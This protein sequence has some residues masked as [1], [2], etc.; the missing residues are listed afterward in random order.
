MGNIKAALFLAYK[1]VTRGNR[2]AL[3]LIILVM[4]LSFMN[5]IFTSSILDGVTDTLDNQL[6]NTLVG[7]VVID[8]SGTDYYIEDTGNIKSKLE[9]V[10]GVSGVST[11][12]DSPAFIEYRWREKDRPDDKG[13]S[14]TWNVV[15][16]EPVAEA[17]VTTVH[18]TLIAGSYLEP[19]DR[20]RILL[21]I[22]I[23]GGEL[24]NSSD[25]LTLGGVAV[26]DWVRLSFPNGIVREYQI[27]GIFRAREIIVT[28]RQAFITRDEMT[29]VM[30]RS[31]F[32]DR[33]SQIIV[34]TADTGNEAT[35]V[36]SFIAMG[37]DGE[38]RAWYEYGAAMR[39]MVS[40]FQVVI[41][42]VSAIGLFVAGIVMFIVIYINVIHKR[43]QIGILRAIGIRRNVVV[44]SFLI[45]A[46]FYTITGVVFGW[47]IFSLAVE[48]Y[49]LMHPI[50]VSIGYISLSV[51]HVMVR[52]SFFGLIAAAVLA[53][54]LPV[55]AIARQGIIETIWGV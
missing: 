17:R 19:G 15:G 7:N 45:Q 20:D 2:W 22:E 50:D 23:A 12:L 8:P 14:G 13:E 54:S 27:K 52:D 32:S 34:R 44:S 11:H 18:E 30:G 9:Q 29:S 43:R 41:S 1:S 55:L 49:F 10:P 40:S 6:V 33:A 25:H 42:M 35:Y 3:G 31:A 51:D 28:D 5:L 16:I 4:S 36:D 24:A 39:G 47:A 21:G 53:G 26:G 46:L 48:P 37:I 38:I